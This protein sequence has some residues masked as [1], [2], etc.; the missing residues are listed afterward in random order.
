MLHGKK[1]YFVIVQKSL[2]HRTHTSCELHNFEV[3]I[4][5]YCTYI[6]YELVPISLTSLLNGN[7]FCLLLNETYFNLI[8]VFN[9]CGMYQNLY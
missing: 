6:I 1:K 8:I 3:R 4:L 9:I 2:I 7:N 5:F